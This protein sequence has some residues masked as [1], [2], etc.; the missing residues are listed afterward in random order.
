MSFNLFYSVLY[1]IAD[2]QFVVKIVKHKY[3]LSSKV[4]RFLKTIWA[5]K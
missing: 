5:K 2:P 3:P 1:N 4:I